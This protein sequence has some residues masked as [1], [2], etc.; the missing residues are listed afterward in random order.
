MPVWQCILNNY[1]LCCG[2]TEVENSLD[3]KLLIFFTQK[4]MWE[5]HV[6]RT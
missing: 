1:A 5:K 6:T 2:F 4:Y 3:M